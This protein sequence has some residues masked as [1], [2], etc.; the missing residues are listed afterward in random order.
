MQVVWF[1]RDL[2]VQDNSALEQAS[3]VGPVLPLYVVETELWQQA[4]ASA[5][6][7][8]FVAETL[9]ELRKDLGALGQ[10]LVIRVGQIQSVFSALKE[11]GLIEALWSHEETGNHWTYQRDLQVAAWCRDHGI[12]WVEVQNHGVFRKLKSRDGWAARWDK[13]M[14]LP[15]TSPTPLAPIEVDLGPFPTRRDLGLLDDRCNGRQTGGR[16]AGLERLNSF[17]THRG[18]QYQ[19][20]MSSPVEGAEACS[21]L[22]PYLAWGALSMREVAQTSRRQRRALPP[23]AKDW[24]KS[25]RSF[26]GRLHWH[27]HFI[28]KLE[29]EPR[30]EFENLHRLYD[31]LRPKTPDANLLVAWSN[32]ETGYPFLDACMRSL[33]TTGWLNFRMRA[34]VMATASYHLWLD[35]R[36]P[37]LHLARMFTDYEPG[38]HWNQVQM[39][40]GTTGI[41][42]VRIYNPVKQ[43]YDQDPKG[44]FI[45]T[46]LP[47]LTPI[48]NRYIHEPW[49]AGNATQIIGIAYPERIF[50]HLA[51]AKAARER[52]WGIRRGDDF[53]N[54]ARAIARTHAS[55]KTWRSI[56]KPLRAPTDPAQLN[57]PFGDPT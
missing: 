54:E 5:R 53:R 57:L 9:A 21:R 20:A 22:S 40:S 30:I 4:D 56:Q 24:H 31:G 46:W 47:E 55:R 41:N 44:Q 28:Q 15:T 18:E 43:G 8:N 25:L 16:R 2:R 33:R 42:T 11:Q 36:A 27:C 51:A 12:P 17:L 14:D 32:G 23:R 45:R 26:S 35:W 49:K 34:M 48:A 19:R 39:Q 37:G 38:I 3:R 13:F 6:Q 52:V 10:P 50:D 29:D 7:W 1:K